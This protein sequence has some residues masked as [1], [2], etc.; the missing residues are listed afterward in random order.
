M[1]SLWKRGLH[2]NA[3]LQL[4]VEK[5]DDSETEKTDGLKRHGMGR[6]E[7]IGVNQSLWGESSSV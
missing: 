3:G 6:A 1:E 4:E 5:D 2:P 7:K